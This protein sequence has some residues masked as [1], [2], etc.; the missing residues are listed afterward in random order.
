MVVTWLG[1]GKNFASSS[2]ARELRAKTCGVLTCASGMAGK[3]WDPCGEDGAGKVGYSSGP[4]DR[5]EYY[6]SKG[7]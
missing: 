5:G 4:H 1:V 6:N 3:E 7:P 2:V